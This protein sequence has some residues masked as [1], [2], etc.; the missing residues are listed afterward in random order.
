MVVVLVDS[1]Q[2]GLLGV[3]LPCTN[4]AQLSVNLVFDKLVLDRRSTA[5]VVYVLKLDCIYDGQTI[6]INNNLA[7]FIQARALD[8]FVVCAVVKL[9]F[10]F[11]V[12][13][14]TKV[15]STL[16][17]NTSQ[18]K[19]VIQRFNQAVGCGFFF[20]NF[21]ITRFALA[22]L[23]NLCSAFNRRLIA[24]VNGRA[25]QVG[26]AKQVHGFCVSFGFFFDHFS[27]RSS[28]RLLH[29]QG[30][31]FGLRHR[32]RR[33]FLGKQLTSLTTLRLVDGFFFKD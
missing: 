18:V 22:L 13:V 9:G 29:G 19:A 28:R 24:V 14:L 12:V 6:F 11:V 7:V 17:L 4:L 20:L 1:F 32:N 16:T 8:S 5:F 30:F 15:V 26:F 21:G 10:L 2:H 25:K 3:A 33:F 23:F 31:F 27:R